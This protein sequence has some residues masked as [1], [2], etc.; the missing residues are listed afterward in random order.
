[1][2][3]KYAVCG[4]PIAHSRSP[5]IHSFFAK[6]LK[7]DLTY[8]TLL[9][10][11]GKFKE[12]VDDFVSKGGKGLNITVPCKLEACAYA[13]E[14]SPYAKAAGAVNVLKFNQ[15]GSVFGDN[16]DGRG[17][18]YDLKR[19]NLPIR[20]QK[21]LL[22]GAGGAA[23]GLIKP[24]FEEQPLEVTIVNRTPQK[25][26]KIAAE[27]GYPLQVTGYE[28]LTAG[29]DLVVNCTSTSLRHELPPVP[30]EVLRH[31][32]V[33]YDLMYATDEET[34]FVAEA[35]S[36]GVPHCIDGL[37]MLIAQAALTYAL[38]RGKTPDV[39]LSIEHFRSHA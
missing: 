27:C 34:S 9:V 15:D 39:N 19:L 12:T 4:N 28:Q 22:L 13:D 5:Q 21:V 11:P 25:A 14:L 30:Q 23:Q 32:K 2:S 17:F 24:V 16:T 38:W 10:P 18:I 3:D 37:G 35:R 29:Y 36:L 20:G 8:T 6:T 26:E 31:C 1:M 33:A 7:D